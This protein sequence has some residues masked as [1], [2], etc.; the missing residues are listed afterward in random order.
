MVPV[1]EEPYSTEVPQLPAPA[2]KVR[3]YYDTIAISYCAVR[4]C[5][6]QSI[7]AEGNTKKQQQGS[8]ERSLVTLCAACTTQISVSTATRY[9]FARYNPV[10]WLV[11]AEEGV[12]EHC[13]AVQHMHSSSATSG[14]VRDIAGQ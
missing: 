6:A 4:H 3:Y 14:L 13:S 2:I 10:A 11:A 7:C 9:R 1:D 5:A 12:Q 8:S